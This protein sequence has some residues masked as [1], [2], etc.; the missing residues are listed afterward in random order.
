MKT[1]LRIFSLLALLVPPISLAEQCQPSTNIEDPVQFNWTDEGDHFSGIM[2]IAPADLVINGETI[3]TRV[4]RQQ[5]GC[6]SIPGPTM[7]MV[8]GKKYVLRFNN[9]LPYEVPSTE[10]NVFKNPNVSNLHTH[11]LHISGETPGDDVTRN[12]PGGYGGDFVYDIHS[13]HM[14]GTFWYHAHHHGSTYLQVSGGAFGLIV[15]EDA[16]DGIPA[17]VASMTERQLVIAY[18]DPDVAGTG[19]DT[20]ITGTLSPTWTVNGHVNG[21]LVMPPNTWQHFRILLADRDAKPKA[22]SIGPT[23]EVALLARDGVWRTTAPLVLGDGSITI[24][25]ASRADLAVRCQA[26]SSISVAGGQ[27]ASI[28]LQGSEDTGPSPYADGLAGTWQAL[29]PDYLRDL[30]GM[31]NVNMETVNMG[32]RTINGSKFDMEVPTFAMDASGVQEWALKGARNHPFH[33][34]IYH[35]QIN[36][37][38]ADYEDGEYYDVVANNCA[39]RFDLNAKTSSVYEGRTIMHCHILEHEDQGAMGWLRVNEGTG[40]IGPPVF[41]GGFGY[42]N[43]YAIDNPGG[44]PPAAPGNLVAIAATS[45]Q[46]NLSWDDNSDDELTFEIESSPDPETV[47]FGFVDYVL[48]GATTYQDTGLA[49]DSTWYYRVKATNNSGSSGYSN[50]AS[51]TTRAAPVAEKM[52]IDSISVSAPGAGGGLRKGSAT[53]VIRDD[54][55]GLVEGATVTGEFSLEIVED[56]VSGTTGSDGS[57]TIESSVTTTGK[58][59]V[60][61]LEFCV[62]GVTHPTLTYADMGANCGLL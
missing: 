30:R 7:K 36:G 59:K 27:V 41:P 25:G 9:L 21:N 34:H 15:V 5:D 42:M 1:I 13:D 51:A 28:T 47:G 23:C 22:V 11:G 16:A 62:T 17:K 19:G 56:G 3:T 39:I 53:V 61:N 26:D 48:A 52:Y 35:V 8:P 57:T 20:L 58:G 50:E 46:I 6:D 18:L 14:G 32:A 54:A 29:R 38:C 45:S 4:Y 43:E 24:T 55:G 2:E 40:G 31:N 33:L 12:F 10:H 44:T 49:A 60:N 37:D